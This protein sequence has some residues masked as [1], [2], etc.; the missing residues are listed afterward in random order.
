LNSTTPCSPRPRMLL[1]HRMR[2]TRSGPRWRPPPAM[3]AHVPASLTT[4]RIP[5]QAVHPL[6]THLWD[7]R[8]PLALDAPTSRGLRRSIRRG[9]P[10]PPGD[11][12]AELAR[13]GHQR[14]P[15]LSRP[16]PGRSRPASKL[17]HNTLPGAPYRIDSSRSWLA[18]APGSLHRRR[19][20]RRPLTL[21]TRSELRTVPSARLI[22]EIPRHSH[23]SE[24]RAPSGTQCGGHRHS[25]H[26]RC[27][28]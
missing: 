27:P 18:T 23:L 20:C 14:G 2:R 9:I 8:V 25:Q 5:V 12:V 11:A 3:T 4:R 26:R 21:S 13:D 6:A 10:G 19:R 15:I 7:R 16:C 24:E 22:A 1:A 28:R 17:M